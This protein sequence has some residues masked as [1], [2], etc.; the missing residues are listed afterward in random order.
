MAGLVGTL[1]PDHTSL[2][3]GSCTPELHVNKCQSPKKVP[4][5]PVLFLRRFPH[6]CLLSALATVALSI[7]KF[8]FFF[9][10]LFRMSP[11]L[12]FFQAIIITTVGCSM[13]FFSRNQPLVSEHFNHSVIVSDNSCCFMNFSSTSSYFYRCL[14]SHYFTEQPIFISEIYAFAV[15]HNIIKMSKALNIHACHM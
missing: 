3:S 10:Q 1:A 2:D 13:F 9:K 14:I 5:N 8:N 11:I 6:F 15:F 7:G 4:S 12:Y